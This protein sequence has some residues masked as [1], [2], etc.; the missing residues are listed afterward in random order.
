MVSIKD[1]S[2]LTG[3]STATISRV[4]NNSPKVSPKTRREVMDAISATGY[5]PNFFGRNLRTSSS[6]KILILLPTTE[7]TFYG[8]ILRG[9]EET[10]A[11]AG[12]QIIIGVTQNDAAIERKYIDM[13]LS[14]QVDGLILANTSMDKF[15]VN[16]LAESFPVVL[17]A[18]TI[19]GAITPSVTIDNIQ[20]AYD[21]T[22]YLNSLGHKKI[23]MIS[24]VYYQNPSL[25]RETGYLNA[26]KDLQLDAYA[27]IKR[28]DFAFSG[29]YM[30]CKKLLSLTDPPTAV[31]CVADS[32]AIGAEKFLYDNQLQD[33]VSVIGFDNVI[34]SEYF[35][36][37]ISTVN[38]PKFEFGKACVELVLN[39]IADL[40]APN[41]QMVIPHN[42]V[43]R[44]S[45]H[46]LESD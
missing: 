4:V 41:E 25:Q 15:D 23:S 10:A 6:M 42:L 32:I 14:R 11:E 8:D 7:N 28:T 21:A 12:Y 16:R 26:M 5:H 46:P 1:L 45:T 3:Y 35:F 13:L 30:T 24:G 22:T 39:K 38:Q 20:A 34:E 19:D 17:L 43:I 37:G 2:A 18:H 27:S 36:N 44:G 29:G 9:A 40:S 33:K 31:F